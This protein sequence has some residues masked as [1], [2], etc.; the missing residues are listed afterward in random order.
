VGAKNARD[1]IIYQHISGTFTSTDDPAGLNLA[2]LGLTDEVMKKLIQ[3]GLTETGLL[4]KHR[5][6]LID[7]ATGN[8]G[9][10]PP[11]V[12]PIL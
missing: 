8:P 4:Q 9:F 7:P 5:N 1:G 3:N 11:A 2:F 10:R 12:V 6:Q